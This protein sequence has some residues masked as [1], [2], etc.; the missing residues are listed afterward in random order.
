MRNYVDNSAKNTLALEFDSNV[1]SLKAIKN[2]S[3]DFTN[4]CGIQI[5][6]QSSDKVLVYLTP[7]LNEPECIDLLAVD[8][9]NHV[10]DHQ[11]RIEVSNDF[12]LIREMIVAQ[13]FE[14]C[15]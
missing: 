1:Y 9:K 12:K 5:E 10:L 14:P 11:I 3:Y 7:K 4:K 8:F 6:T 13:A 2:A 15:D